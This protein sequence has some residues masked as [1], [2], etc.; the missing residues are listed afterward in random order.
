L[1]KPI[2]LSNCPVEVFPPPVASFIRNFSRASGSQEPYATLAVLACSG[3]ILDGYSIEV[4]PGYIER[5]NGFYALVGQPGVTKTAPIKVALAPLNALES[6]KARKYK[7]L[8][9]CYEA[10]LENCKT[11][12]ERR[13]LKAPVREPAKIITDGSVEGMITQLEGH[14]LAGAPPHVV[15]VRDELKGHFGAMDKYKSKGG[16]DYE[17]WLSLFSGATISK[18]LSTRCVHITEARATVIGSIQ[19]D[20]YQK[21]LE[22]KG[23]GMADRFT[24]AFYDGPPEK[25]D[26][27]AHVGKAI[28]E[29]Y[30]M[31]M[32][33][34][35]EERPCAYSFFDD[36]VPQE[37]TE[38]ILDAVQEFHDWCHELGLKY[39]VGAFKKWEQTFYRFVLILAALWDKEVVDLET[40]KRAQDLAGHFAI[41]WLQSRIVAN[42][43]TAET[44]QAKVLEVLARKKICTRSA[45]T[46]SSRMF[47]KNGDLLNRTLGQMV[48]AGTISQSGGRYACV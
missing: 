47:R 10:E 29:D 24:V 8:K 28:I 46:Q 33:D 9:D 7:L 2:E 5:P 6:K 41:S 17:L 27:R 14:D 40:V 3:G 16:D 1:K 48:Q 34:L 23:D 36:R 31:F 19:P 37:D 30:K 12:E 44:A 26:I 42:K 15:Y 13:A 35:I 45:F 25:T 11:A 21:A 39:D 43:E 22:D 38:A 32:A 20:V 4:K 18:V